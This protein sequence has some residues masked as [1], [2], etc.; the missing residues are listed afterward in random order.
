MLV[1][2]HLE[3]EVVDPCG[4]LRRFLQSAWELGQDDAQA[5]ALE[6]LRFRRFTT[7]DVL[8]AYEA[9]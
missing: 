8:E 4:S 2:H 7:R 9:T 1:A 5:L 3:A 6:L